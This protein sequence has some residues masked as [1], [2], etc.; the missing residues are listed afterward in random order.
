M[1]LISQIGSKEIYDDLLKLGLIPNKSKRLSLPSIPKKY[2]SHFIRGYFDGD[3]S[4]DFGFYQRKDRKNQSFVLLTRFTSGSKA[5][6]QNLLESLR[7]YVGI[8]GG[9][10]YKKQGGY[11]LSF[12]IR[13]SVRLYGFIY[14][15]AKKNQF[16]ER[17]HDEFQ[18][19]IKYYG[20]VA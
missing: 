8:K 6:L 9:S 10:I 15:D 7:E 4:V 1:I 13:D 2:F 12:S 11:D 19:A 18:E 14:K 3:G 16:L 20:G 17:K 5:F